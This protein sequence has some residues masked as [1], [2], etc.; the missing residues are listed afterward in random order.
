MIDNGGIIEEGKRAKKE[1][2]MKA[3]RCLLIL[4]VVAMAIV[5]F[6]CAKQK[7]A[8]EATETPSEGGRVDNTDASAPKTIDS[9]NIVS[10]DTAFYIEKDDTSGENYSGS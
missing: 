3:K 8:L 5:L 2:Q 4:G 9:K 10:F 7:S 1:G 6:G